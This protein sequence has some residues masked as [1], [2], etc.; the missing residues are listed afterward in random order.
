VVAGG[1]VLHLLNLTQLT[2]IIK[3]C[4]TVDAAAAL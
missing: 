4:L 2:S 3:V 1:R